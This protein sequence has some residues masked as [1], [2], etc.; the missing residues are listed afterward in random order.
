MKLYSFDVFDTLITRSTATPQGIFAIMQ[1]LISVGENKGLGEFV[2]NNFYWLRIGAEQVARNTYCVNGIED[3]TLEQIYD[4]LVKEGHISKKQSAFLQELERKTE[5][6]FCVGILKNI[7]RVKELTRA[8]ERIVLISDMYLD[9]DT[10]RKML[11]KVDDV[12][13]DI[14]IYVSSDKEKKNKWTGNLFRLVQEWEQVSYGE[15]KHMGD[16]EHSDYNVPKQMGIECTKYEPEK[17]L[18]IEEAY[19]KNNESDAEVQLS[20]GCARVARMEGKKNTAYRMGCSIGGSI[21]YKYVCWLLEDCTRRDIRRLYFIARDGYVLKELADGL[22]RQNG[23]P[24]ETRYIFG[25]RLAWRIPCGAHY[26]DEIWDIYIHSYQDRVFS[27]EDLADFFQVQ[28]ESLCRYLPLGLRDSSRIWTVEITDLVVRQLLQCSLFMNELRMQ[29]DKKREL[30]LGYL[31]QEIDTSDDRF[32]FVDLAGSGFTQECLARIMRTYFQGEIKNYFFRQDK[33]ENGICRNYVFYPNYVP[34]FVL[35]E[36]VS[37][38]PHGQTTGYREDVGGKI[39]PVLSG[40]DGEAVAAHHVEDFIDGIKKYGMIYDK[41]RRMGQ[42]GFGIRNIF[43]YL[44]YIYN[45]PDKE[46]LDYF[47]DMPNMLTGREKRTASFAPILTNRDIRNMYW[48]REGEAMEY[49]YAGT[50]IVYSLLRC[51]KQQLNKI[52]MYSKYRDTWYGRF[53]RSVHKYL[54]HGKSRTRTVTIYDC[55][56]ENI[57]IYGAGKKGRLFYEQMTGRRKV[58][59]Q[60]YHCNVVI[61][62]DQNYVQYQEQG[63]DVA[64]PEELCSVGFDQIIIAVAKKETADDIKK[65]L[66]GKGIEEYMIIWINPV[67]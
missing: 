3:V 33:T 50:D 32:A 46:V 48:Y 64:D 1:L 40:A 7:S 23:Y 53:C 35:L 34:Y 10:I 55:I 18:E 24:I 20:L 43:Y 17:L 67:G 58:N 15:W 8:G 57:A 63:M 14:P 26:E 42:I 47:A 39:V 25:S 22:I 56:K 44:D 11:V 49:H 51:T 2:K 19:L 45:T 31:Q 60:R 66:L 62:A 6:D 37:R 41:K 38:A 30:L 61:W 21:L 29:Y 28:G 52:D 13:T 12:F 36:M 5:I 59:G 54:D 65:M 9:R 4:V 16:N 27:M